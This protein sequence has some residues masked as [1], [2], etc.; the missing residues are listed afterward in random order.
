MVVVVGQGA[1]FPL[2]SR[3]LSETPA[4]CKERFNQERKMGTTDFTD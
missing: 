3:M 4:G 2:P 1:D